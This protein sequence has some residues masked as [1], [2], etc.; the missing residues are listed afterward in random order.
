MQKVTT[1]SAKVSSGKCFFY[2]HG[3]R[4]IKRCPVSSLT[5]GKCGGALSSAV[6][7]CWLFNSDI[8]DSVTGVALTPVTISQ[9]YSMVSDRKGRVNSAVLLNGAYFQMPAA[10][11]MNGDFSV[12]AWAYPFEYRYWCRIIDVSPQTGPVQDNI[13]LALSAGNSGQPAANSVG[14]SGWINGGAGNTVSVVIP[15]NNWT[16]I[17]S[18]QTGTNS[19]VWIN[20]VSKGNIN[21]MYVPANVIHT[22][23]YIGYSR[24]YPGDQLVNTYFDDVIIFK[25]SLTA[26][27]VTYIYQL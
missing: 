12:S 17:A 15:K 20:G 5:S 2:K 3:K 19:T 16:H 27:E 25:R 13:I 14:P 24:Y 9:A 26:A 21:N 22:Y 1:E 8:K 6:R 18:T 10:N 23:S 7:N 4:T 11:Y